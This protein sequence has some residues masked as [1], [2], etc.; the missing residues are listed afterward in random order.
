MYGNKKASWVLPHGGWN[1]AKGRSRDV[2]AA[3]ILPQEIHNLLRRVPPHGH[4][5]QLLS[6]WLERHAL[7]GRLELQHRAG[8][9][10]AAHPLCPLEVS[11]QVDCLTMRIDAINNRLLGRLSAIRHQGGGR[12]G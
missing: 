9:L 8:A 3:P 4:S 1:P 10:V 2:L 5:Y 6:F 12:H 7:E 11:L